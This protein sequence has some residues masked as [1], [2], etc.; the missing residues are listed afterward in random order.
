MA[1]NTTVFDNIEGT[2]N[3]EAQNTETQNTETQNT[4]QQTVNNEWLPEEYRADKSFAKF[5]DINALAKSYKEMQSLI[6]KK[7]A[8]IPTEESSAEEWSSF[9]KQLGVPESADDYKFETDAELKL[10]ETLADETMQKQ[11][12]DIF[13]EANLTPQQAQILWNARNKYLAE[14]FATAQANYDKSVENVTNQLKK[15]WGDKFN[16]E[17]NKSLQAFRYLYP[18][19]DPADFPLVNNIDFVR[20]L[21]KIHSLIGDDKIITSKTPGNTLAAVESEI[22]EIL[23]NADYQ[24]PMSLNHNSL[25]DRMLELQAQKLKMKGR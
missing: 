13:K 5:K 14:E 10:P 4:E 16:S 24:N 18:D 8:G 6:G 17:L 22:A 11:Y 9:Y 3:T 21:N 1:D 12:R 2:Q 19:T 15:D 23:N 25:M 7:T 20:T